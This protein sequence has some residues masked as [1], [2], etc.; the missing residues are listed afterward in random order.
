MLEKRH[1]AEMRVELVSMGQWQALP[2]SLGL[3]TMVLESEV[4]GSGLSFT[5]ERLYD[6]RKVSLTVSS[7]VSL[8]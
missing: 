2:S 8:L 5:M 7:F 6:P 3:D 4:W 1:Q